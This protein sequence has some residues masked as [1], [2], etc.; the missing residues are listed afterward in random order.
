M[1]GRP[2]SSVLAYQIRCS[3]ASLSFTISRAFMDALFAYADVVAGVHMFGEAQRGFQVTSKVVRSRC[4]TPIMSLPAAMGEIELPADC[5]PL[6]ARA[7]P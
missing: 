5:A 4:L 7:I 1:Q 6:R 3:P 2:I